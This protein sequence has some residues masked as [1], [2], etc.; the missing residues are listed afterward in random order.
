MERTEPFVAQTQK[1]SGSACLYCFGTPQE[2]IPRRLGVWPME[3]GC[4]GT[5]LPCTIMYTLLMCFCLSSLNN[6]TCSLGQL[7]SAETIFPAETRVGAM[8][9]LKS[10][11][12]QKGSPER[13]SGLPLRRPSRQTRTVCFSDQLLVQSRR[14]GVQVNG[15]LGLGIG[16]HRHRICICMTRSFVRWW[17]MRD[18]LT[19]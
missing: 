1:R 12:A 3:G 14:N 2:T 9:E 10:A 13:A 19:V 6:Q 15:K 11:L 5:P 4:H 17:I 16:W 18:L 7:F 8:A